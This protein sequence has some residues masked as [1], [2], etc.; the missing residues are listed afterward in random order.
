[1]RCKYNGKSQNTN[2]LKILKGNSHLTKEEIEQRKEDEVKADASD[3][4]SYL[5]FI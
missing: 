4:H 5:Y 2:R 1:M 3:I